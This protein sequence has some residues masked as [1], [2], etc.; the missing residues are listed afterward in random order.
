MIS[1]DN[2]VQFTVFCYAVHCGLDL[3]Q[4]SKCLFLE[5]V[6]VCWSASA[7]C[8]SDAVLSVRTKKPSSTKFHSTSIKYK[9]GSRY[10]NNAD[11]G[12]K[13]R[14]VCMKYSVCSHRSWRCTRESELIWRKAAWQ[15][16][17]RN[18]WMSS[19]DHEARA[20]NQF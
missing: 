17:A 16:G 14:C 8:N 15:S 1:A 9:I 3:L 12:N 4:N 7:A 13:R 20:A 19:L 11:A 18:E 5:S 2:I 6:R 10:H